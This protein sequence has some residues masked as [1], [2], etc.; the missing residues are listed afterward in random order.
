MTH[1]DQEFVEKRFFSE[2]DPR[3]LGIWIA[4]LPEEIQDLA[5]TY[6]R[7]STEKS[8]DEIATMFGLTSEE[9]TAVLR[10]AEASIMLHLTQKAHE[11]ERLE[12]SRQRTNRSKEHMQKMQEARRGKAMDKLAQRKKKSDAAVVPTGHVSQPEI[13]LSPETPHLT[14]EQRNNKAAKAAR[15]CLTISDKEFSRFLSKRVDEQK[16]VRDT[17][18][19]GLGCG[20][21]EACLEEAL[22]ARYTQGV[23]GG[24]IRSELKILIAQRDARASVPIVGTELL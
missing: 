6:E 9:Y 10:E 24:K 15:V 23:A 12:Y 2:V 7:L 11:K 13:E 5:Y 8:L 4:T 14:D 17:Y 16:Y 1:N 20:A 19:I 21:I 18:C 22:Q 3:S